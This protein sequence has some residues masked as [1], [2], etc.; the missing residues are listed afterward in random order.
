MK[1]YE[2]KFIYFYIIAI[3]LILGTIIIYPLFHDIQAGTINYFQLLINCLTFIAVALY[4]VTSIITAQKSAESVEATKKLI[5]VKLKPQ[6][7]KRKSI[8]LQLLFESRDNNYV[9]EYANYFFNKMIVKLNNSEK[10][11][12]IQNI[13]LNSFIEKL[14]NTLY[15]IYLE[16]S[17]Y[18]VL[19]EANGKNETLRA[20][21][22]H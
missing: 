8:A 19:T 22:A 4:V 3:T 5:E 10:E 20:Y 16:N 18:F 12:T 13:N 2:K 7:V 6:E 21:I 1:P 17:Y 11:Q 15:K 9:L 14:D